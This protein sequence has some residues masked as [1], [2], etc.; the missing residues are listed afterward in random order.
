MTTAIMP[1]QTGSQTSAVGSMV[2]AGAM[3]VV[4]VGV[5][6]SW[7]ATASTYHV[8]TPTTERTITGPSG[9][10][11]L[12]QIGTTAGAILEI[13]RRSGL[14][15]EELANLFDVS[16]RSVHHWA[17]GKAVTPRHD[18][19]IR[20]VL[21]TI[22][23][24]DRG[25]AMRTRDLL[26]TPDADGVPIFDLLKAER[27]DEAI[28]RV[29]AMPQRVRLSLTEISQ[30]ALRARRPAPPASLVGALHDRP[31]IPGKARVARAVRMPKATS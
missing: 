10:V 13:R 4:L 21:A 18:Q 20:R 3:G 7:P 23:Q 19:L 16:R 26:L 28:A 9:Q 1:D 8:Y 22:R 15:W 24:L 17:S 14:T 29:G 31:D 11:S 25:E 12:P 27:F 6:L 30:E 2:R 5:G